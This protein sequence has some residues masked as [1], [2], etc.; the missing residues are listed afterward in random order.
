MYKR[1]SVR[2]VK[3]GELTI[4]G[5]KHV[6]IQS[7]TNTKTKDY[8]KTIEQILE[9]EK[10]GCEI[11]RVAVLDME[12]AKA[13]KRIK[14]S[15][16]IPLVAD[17]HF[18]YM[19]AIESIKNGV[20]KIRLNPGNIKNRNHI[21]EV[22]SLCRKNK[23]PIRIGVNSGSLPNLEKPS[24]ENMIR[25][26]KM[27]VDILES[28]NFFDIIISLKVSD[29]KLMIDTYLEA[30]KIFSYPL[31]LGV[32]EAGPLLIGTV[33]NSLGIGLLLNMGIGN[34][35]RVSLT[36]DPVNEVL[37]AKEILKN[38]G[39]RN[40]LPNLISCPTC[41][42]LEYNLIPIVERVEKYLRDIDK[43][44]SVAIMGCRVNGPGEA[45]HADLG[46]AGGDGVGIIFKKG[47]IVKTVPE[48]TLYDC[49]VEEINKL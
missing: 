4:G 28:L 15:I 24:V 37:V 48:D 44:I 36:S 14:E 27:H 25:V 20:D 8:L 45:S 12:D 34:T 31:H 2:Q 17:I 46:V 9:L 1:D 47:K 43:N 42:R 19:L 29:P 13:I 11:V 32:T 41:G 22:V 16:H 10:A 5:N 40:D 30:A 49:L 6:Y 39:L 21:E 3:V 26:C 38:L 7:M 33:K 35:I 18:D 23:I